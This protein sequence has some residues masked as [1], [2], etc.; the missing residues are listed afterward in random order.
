MSDKIK[1][2]LSKELADASTASP[3]EA[4]ENVGFR[5]LY[6]ALENAQTA[7][8][9]EKYANVIGR[10]F[11]HEVKPNIDQGKIDNAMKKMGNIFDTRSFLDGTSEIFNT[12]FEASRP[13]TSAL[14][15]L[16]VGRDLLISSFD[17]KKSEMERDI[18]RRLALKEIK[19]VIEPFFAPIKKDKPPSFFKRLFG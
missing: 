11:T 19:Q 6:D 14:A 5:E 15:G 12:Q 9:A 2:E 16:Q 4:L 3:E 10:K 1:I 13:Y 8:D 17:E 7:N 18:E